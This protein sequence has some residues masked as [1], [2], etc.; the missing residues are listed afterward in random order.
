MLVIPLLGAGMSDCLDDQEVLARDDHGTPTFIVGSLGSLDPAKDL[1]EEAIA[2]LEQFSAREWKATGKEELSVLRLNRDQLGYVHVR[3]QQRIHGLP[4]VGAQ[5]IVHA[6]EFTGEVYAVNGRFVSSKGLR[7][8]PRMAAIQALEVAAEDADIS[9]IVLDEPELVYR[10]GR[11]GKVHLAWRN[12][13]QYESKNGLEIDDLFADAQTGKLVARLPKI[14]RAKSWRTYDA[15]NGLAL[16]GV[17][18]CVNSQTCSDAI[19]QTIHDSASTVYDYYLEKHD[20]LSWDGRDSAVISSAHS[21]ATHWNENAS[22][23]AFEDGDGIQTGP[24]GNAFDVVAHEFT[25]GVTLAMS[26]L[27]EFEETGALFE[28]WS[29]IFGA[30]AEAWVD[31]GISAD[32]WKFAEDIW[33]P[34]LPGDAVRYMNDPVLD[35][36]SRDFYPERY[37]DSVDPHLNAGIANLAF[38]LAVEGGTHPRGKTTAVVTPVGH[39]QA[40]QIFYRAHQYLVSQATFHDARRATALAA[41]DLYGTTSRDRISNAWCAVGVCSNLNSPVS[42]QVQPT[43]CLGWTFLEWSPVPGAIRYEVYSSLSPNFSIQTKIFDGPA[44]AEIFYIQD[45]RKYLR[46]R[47]CDAMACGDY[48]R[49]DRST[50]FFPSCFFP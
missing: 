24:Q 35:G 25:H 37:P 36:E 15:E 12:R 23:M 4:V 41:L 47:G 34:G 7:S 33:T 39:A 5:A 27:E 17:L 31:G 45:P 50:R 14:H 8:R 19:E 49:G 16:L 1:G 29:D 9:G 20:H 32:T 44:T 11:D 22:Q 48:K 6:N 42:F 40:E 30:M 3:I 10:L 18:K 38:Y 13:V 21:Y 28:A 26:G 2:F 43:G 46:V